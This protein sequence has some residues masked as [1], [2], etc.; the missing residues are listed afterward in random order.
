MT[1]TKITNSE[2]DT[3]EE[4]KEQSDARIILGPLVKY[5][6]VGFVLVSI[7]I[8]TAVMLDRQFN[9]IDKE[10]A[11]LQAQLAQA[12]VDTAVVVDDDS[13]A[14]SQA[15]AT[16]VIE[17]E[18]VQQEQMTADVTEAVKPAAAPT[19]ENSVDT[20]PA[21][22]QTAVQ[23]AETEVIVTESP[24]AEAAVADEK[25][26]PADVTDKVNRQPGF[27]DR[28]FDELI[29]ERNQYLEEMDRVYLEDL[30]ASRER[31]LQ[32]MRDRIARQEQRI[33][34]MEQRRREIY[35]YRA[36]DLKEM[37]Q[38]R[39]YFLPDRI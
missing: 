26:V 12:N 37:Q 16:P 20:M 4:Q 1:D 2:I 39:E 23:E 18:A 5:A 15:D 31:H 34:E 21:V 3:K 28:S 24:V 33:Q 14:E 17:V 36:A 27:F 9:S 29:A 38:R 35:D 6:A 13:T 8:T 32:F 7:I 10:V 30:R 25:V 22:I 19:V 11:E